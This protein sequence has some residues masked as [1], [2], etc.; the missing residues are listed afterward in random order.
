MGR[1]II[2][3]HKTNITHRFRF[4][5][6]IATILLTPIFMYLIFEYITG[7][8]KH[9]Q[10]IYIVLNLVFYYIFYIN[11]LLLTN[12]VRFSFTILNLA[13]FVLA[14]AEYFV[15]LFRAR[16]I[17]FADIISVQTGI[18][19]A[20]EYPFALTQ[21]LIWGGVF[22]LVL[23]LLAWFNSFR[24]QQL[25]ARL[26]APVC[27]LLLSMLFVYAFYSNILYKFN[28][29]INMWNPI[30]TYASSG[31]VLSSMALAEYMVP[32]KPQGYNLKHVD[33]LA[34]DITGKE[35]DIK[36]PYVPDT[37]I[38]PSNII[39]I[40]NESYAD[41][42]VLDH[43]HTDV[44]YFKNYRRL[45]QSTIKGNL[46]SPVYGAMTSVPEFEFLT[47][48]SSSFTQ[49]GSVAY[50]LYMRT[51]SHSLVSD[52]KA[53]GYETIAMHPYPAENWNRKHA[54][55]AMG[56]DAFYDIDYYE[57][58]ETIRGYVSDRANFNRIIE[59]T[60]QKESNRPLF[61]FNV[62]MQNHG[63]YEDSSYTPT[64]RF[65]PNQD[66]P[67]AEQY[68][69]LLKET[70]DALGDFLDYYK[71]IDEPTMIVMF[72]DHQPH[73]E[74][75]FYEN[76]YGKDLLSLTTAEDL[77]RYITPFFIWTNYDTPSMQVEKTTPMYLSNIV[78]Q[79][80][81]LPLNTYRYMIEILNQSI[82]VVHAF[83]YF[84]YD[85]RWVDWADWRR[86][87]NEAEY[88][89]LNDYWILLHNNMFEKMFFR[90]DSI[91]TL[92]Q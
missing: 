26:L 36:L 91:F 53:N 42:S 59:V 55:A 84:T 44:D 18:S 69:S 31:Y 88:Q 12:S 72:G 17:M 61:I 16:P 85:D 29:S 28:L 32:D 83:G 8:L 68:L 79:R 52:L 67:R 33:E 73:L 89:L 60:K 24:I 6:D 14:I 86:P 40:M 20:S 76:L 25:K 70:D 39:V 34:A 10:G 65:F 3:E 80:A 22:V 41:L 58:A 54:Y 1:K 62:S 37:D 92:E 2:M 13:L 50:Q 9:I 27:S 66:F 15:T 30:Q 38:V 7:N 51:P 46:Y 43:F 77:Q 71:N 56:F 49:G 48:N 57:G 45:K 23:I 4:F 35:A 64:N 75:A 5:M 11:L 78:L 74:S 87:E 19:V 21:P 63:G 90:R 81:N 82:P 47:S